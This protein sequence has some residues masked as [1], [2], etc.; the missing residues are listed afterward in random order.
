MHLE[1]LK[2]EN[3]DASTFK[4]YKAFY[5]KHV[6]ENPNKSN[7]NNAVFDEKIKQLLSSEKLE[8]YLAKYNDA[9]V[10]AFSCEAK[11]L[12]NGSYLNLDVFYLKN[13]DMKS[14]TEFVEDNIAH[15]IKK[16]QKLIFITKEK[17]LYNQLIR[18]GFVRKNSFVS[19]KLTIKSIDQ[20]MLQN[21]VINKNLEEFDLQGGFYGNPEFEIVK[22]IAP[23]KSELLND[24]ICEDKHLPVR[25]TTERKMKQIETAKKENKVNLFFLLKRNE[26]VVGMSELMYD[27]SKPKIAQQF[28]TGIKKELI[29]N[30]LATYMKAKM[31]LYFL[32]EY[33]KLETVYTNCFSTNAPMIKINKRLGFQ[34]YQTMDELVYEKTI[35]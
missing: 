17:A 28:M 18:L 32:K 3:N 27:Y 33:P 25:I 26:D 23:F 8:I 1:I 16:N 4:M 21:I 22:K 5:F 19:F 30:G 7:I 29:G 34:L 35:L 15:Q 20:K 13:T 24:M 2:L 10:A 6:T 31:Y 14:L 12:E 9:V 11:P